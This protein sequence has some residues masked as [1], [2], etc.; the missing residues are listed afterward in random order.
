VKLLLTSG[1]F[2]NHR[3]VEALKGL[4]GRPFNKL[5]LVFIPTASN[6]EIGGKEWLIDDLYRTKQ[7]GFEKIAVAVMVGNN[8]INVVSEGNWEK[9][10]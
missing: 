10:N 7:L 6:V 9:F 3:I 8:K 1:G 5:K 2:T 4:T